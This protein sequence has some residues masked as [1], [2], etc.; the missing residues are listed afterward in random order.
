MVQ[1]RDPTIAFDFTEVD[2]DQQE[3]EGLSH[4][5]EQEY[6]SCLNQ[7]LAKLAPAEAQSL[8]A[9]LF[10]YDRYKL[11]YADAIDEQEEFVTLFKEMEEKV[12][13]F[14]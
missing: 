13:N 10:E 3:E 8:K 11:A 4:E 7:L 12:E 2:P 5:L 9:I 14:D 1:K 6:M